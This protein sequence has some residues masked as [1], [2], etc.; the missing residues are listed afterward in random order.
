MNGQLPVWGE[1][2]EWFRGSARLTLRFFVRRLPGGP[3]TASNGGAK[4]DTIDSLSGQLRA[5]EKPNAD[6]AIALITFES[7]GVIYA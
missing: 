6:W 2:G 3:L 5:H 1:K 7:K 4:I